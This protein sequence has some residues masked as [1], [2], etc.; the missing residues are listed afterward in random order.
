MAQRNFLSFTRGVEQSADSFLADRMLY[1][2]SF[3]F[4]PVK[5]YK[6]WFERLPIKPENLAKVMGGNACR[7]L[8]L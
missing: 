6:N 1:A 7:L 3:P 2:S 5:D 4:C 8:G